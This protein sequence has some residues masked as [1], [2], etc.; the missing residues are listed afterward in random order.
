[1]RSVTNI[2]AV[3]TISG[4]IWGSLLQPNPIIRSF[5]NAQ[6]K[7]ENN[8]CILCI[9]HWTVLCPPIIRCVLSVQMG[10][11]Q[12]W[13]LNLVCLAKKM[14]CLTQAD[15]RWQPLASLGETHKYVL[16]VLIH[17]VVL[18]AST[19]ETSC[20][21]IRWQQQKQQ[22]EELRPFTPPPHNADGSLSP[23]L[24]LHI[25]T[26][27]TLSVFYRISDSQ[28]W[29]L[30][31]WDFP[32]Q[33]GSKEQ[34]LQKWSIRTDCAQPERAPSLQ[35]VRDRHNGTFKWAS[36]KKRGRLSRV[37]VHAHQGLVWGSLHW[38]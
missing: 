13:E 22:D 31:T 10:I 35:C 3:S 1:M 14:H 29:R 23:P 16:A 37:A 25:S 30:V 15:E 11:Q 9:S 4:P 20:C 27:C 18:V 28:M 26:A 12:D 33:L 7:S 6:C 32:A 21:V 5:H 8:H 36:G 2:E 24:L 17:N 19:V 34:H 38:C